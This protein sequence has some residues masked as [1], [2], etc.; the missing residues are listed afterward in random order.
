[1]TAEVAPGLNDFVIDAFRKNAVRS[2]ILIDE[3]FPNLGDMLEKEFPDEPPVPVRDF[4]EGRTAKGLY[5]ALHGE[6]I[7]CDIANLATDWAGN[8]S[9]RIAEA[10]L[11]V[12]DLHL[13]GG[14]DATDSIE[15]LRMLAE[16]AKFNLVCI[17]TNEDQLQHAAR[18]VAGSLRQ[19]SLSQLST[20]SEV[21]L[22]E[23][24]AYLKEIDTPHELLIDAY[25]LNAKHTGADFGKFDAALTKK[26]P[27]LRPEKW[28]VYERIAAHLL[29]A[30]YKGL[31]GTKSHIPIQADLAAR[32]PWIVYENLMLCFANKALTLPVKIL[33]IVDQ[34][35][36][37]WRPGL[38]RTIIAY[39]RNTV[40]RRGLEFRKNF[41]QDA[42]TQVGWVWHATNAPADSPTERHASQTLLRRL[43]TV[44]QDQVALDD[45][46]ADFV[47]NALA[48]VPRHG[49]QIAQLAEAKNWVGRESIAKVKDT[50]FLHALNSFQSTK[51]YTEQFVTTGTI[52]RRVEGHDKQWLVCVE[53]ACDTVPAQAP[54]DFRFMQVRM[55]ELVKCSHD[56]AEKIARTATQSKYLFVRVDGN[57]EYL[58]VVN[59]E[60]GHP[61]LMNAYV[62]RE[63]QIIEEQGRSM[64]NILLP[65]P[66]LDTP[67]F[68]TVKYEVIAQL[69]E[70]YANRLLH[71][72]GFHLS[73]I[74]LD[75]VEIVEAPRV[76]AAAAGAQ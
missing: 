51:S 21:A 4:P 48:L 33:E 54:E 71:L 16:N 34:S 2:A 46:L 20:D 38:P 8:L 70:P 50:D 24:Y 60:S 13:K 73:R 27:A 53:P 74:G 14:T 1:M 75:F 45:H 26:F 5:R 56:D 69:H 40:T 68:E 64:V 65:N 66:R 12:L 59:P 58:S 42:A 39:L 61:K 63:S 72:A 35:L 43:L 10:D 47:R 19:Q 30:V 62:R 22:E 36:L 9:S 57:R 15:I 55:L 76:A 29:G 25:L 3:N 52:M 23:V 17:Y 37:G 49:N 18:M 7:T 6:G 32:N 44:F 41:P 31:N 11:V 28:V 67:V